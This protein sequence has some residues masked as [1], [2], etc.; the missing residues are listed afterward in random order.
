MV[1]K[2]LLLVF[3]LPVLTFLLLACACYSRNQR[4]RVGDKNLLAVRV[5]FSHQETPVDSIDE[6]EAAIFGTGPNP[7]QVSSD[8]TLVAQIKAISHGKLEFVPV[9]HPSLTR[10]GLL[11]MVIPM[12]YMK[13]EDFLA[14]SEFTSIVQMASSVFADHVILCLPNGILD[15]SDG[16]I[17][18]KG[19]IFTY[20]HNG[21]CLE[22][23]MLMHELGHSLDFHHSGV[24]SQEYGD[25][26]CYMGGLVRGKR[27]PK[28][29]KIT[30]YP[31]KAF[32]GQKH[33]TSG[34]FQDRALEIFPLKGEGIFHQRL[35]SF[36]EYGN[37][38]MASNDVVLLRA[39]Q[40]RQGLQC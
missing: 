2:L 12:G 35:V 13:Y 6:I 31:K 37:A 4:K 40:S 11:D 10:P 14:S 20:F 29:T 7:L 36:V 15:K 19:G 3:A 32:N 25:E 18:D 16:A 39:V 24:A 38:A 23:D 26:T 8:G 28:G 21:Y 27:S 1:R 34:W 17:G 30:G 33:W 9:E 5:P 22:L